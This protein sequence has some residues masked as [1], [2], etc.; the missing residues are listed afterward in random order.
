M[1]DI[2][3]NFD[4]DLSAANVFE[5]L[6]DCLSKLA[7]GRQTIE[8]GGSSGQLYKMR[9]NGLDSLTSILKCMVEW[10]REVYINPHQQNQQSKMIDGGVIEDDQ[11][12]DHEENDQLNQGNQISELEDDPRQFEK[13][14]QHKHILEYGIQL[15]SSK[16]AKG[17]KY[18]EEHGIHDGTC[19]V[20]NKS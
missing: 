17:I 6:V 11:Q 13:V 4:C 1:I 5:R 19:K 2:Y 15:F 20:N 10:S 18:L 16:P 14:K 8:Y 7:Q 3:V 12:E 9:L